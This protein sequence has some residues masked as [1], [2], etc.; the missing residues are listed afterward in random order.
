MENR[1]DVKG[2]VDRSFQG[3]VSYF[4]ALRNRCSA[5]KIDFSFTPQRLDRVAGEVKT[6]LARVYAERYGVNR[7]ES[8]LEQSGRSMK[9]EIQ[10]AAF[11][12]G[13]FAGGIH[14]QLA[15]RTLLIGKDFA[16]EGALAQPVIQGAL[17][18]DLIFFN[19]LA[20]G[21][22]YRLQIGTEEEEDHARQAD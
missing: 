7:T 20:D 12:N 21:T 6:E 11:L 8:Q 10:L 2:T 3:T 18:V 14:R 13:E 17:R 15:Q 9:T 16:T 19:V 5:L 22:E 4:V 1:I